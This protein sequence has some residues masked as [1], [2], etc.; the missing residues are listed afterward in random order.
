MGMEHRTLKSIEMKYFTLE[1]A[2]HVI[3][4][5]SN[6]IL[7]NLIKNVSILYQSIF[8]LLRAKVDG[9]ISQCRWLMFCVWHNNLS[10][11]ILCFLKPAL[12]WNLND[13]NETTKPVSTLKR[14][15]YWRGITSAKVTCISLVR[16]KKWSQNKNDPCTFDARQWKDHATSTR[17]RL[18]WIWHLITSQAWHLFATQHRVTWNFQ[19]MTISCMQSTLTDRQSECQVLHKFTEMDGLVFY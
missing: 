6:G 14:P 13:N 15:P 5:E 12:V 10:W 2:T 16:R 4:M 8:R 1:K 7:G 3:N 18:S 11:Q 9:P 17:Q 19:E